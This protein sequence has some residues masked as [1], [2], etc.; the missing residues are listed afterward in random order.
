MLGVLSLILPF[1]V[2]FLGNGVLSQIAGYLQKKDDTK[3]RILE[4]EVEFA[5]E[6]NRARQAVLISDNEHFIVWFP[7]FVLFACVVAWVASVFI[8]SM[9]SNIDYIIKDVPEKFWWI[10]YAVI[11]YMTLD[12]TTRNIKK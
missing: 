5:I 7:K 2:K 9:F 11:G 3:A 6:Q 4:A 10:V 1:I 8:V 12:T